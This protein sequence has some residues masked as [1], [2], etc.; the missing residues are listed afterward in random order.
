MRIASCSPSP[1]KETRREAV[2]GAKTL[3]HFAVVSLVC[4]T[5]VKSGFSW[6]WLFTRLRW[7]GFVDLG[8]VLERKCDKERQPLLVGCLSL[9]V[10][11]GW[12]LWGGDGVEV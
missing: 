9:L 11:L 6:G 7:W 8:W 12:V 4:Q 5:G 3:P 1:L 10:G 2:G